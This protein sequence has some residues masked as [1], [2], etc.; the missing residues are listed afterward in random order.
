VGWIPLAGRRPGQPEQPV[1]TQGDP[2]RGPRRLALTSVHLEISEADAVALVT[3]VRDGHFDRAGTFRDIGFDAA[4][5][6][7]LERHRLVPEVEGL[8][9]VQTFAFD[10]YR[11]VGQRR[12]RGNTVDL[13]RAPPEVGWLEVLMEYPLTDVL[14][15]TPTL[16]PDHTIKINNMLKGA[17]GTDGC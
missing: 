2:Q 9:R 12:A 5:A 6:A 8:R 3:T 17:A 7:D 4:G 13:H 11:S 1:D 16:P 10:E 15:R 14:A